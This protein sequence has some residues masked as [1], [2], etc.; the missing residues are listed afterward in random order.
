MKK[1]F[2]VFLN[3]FILC[4][5]FGYGVNAAELPEGEQSEGEEH[6][7]ATV[8]DA[9]SQITEKYDEK[10]GIA[11][12][13]LMFCAETGARD[14]IKSGYAFFI[15]DESNVYLISCYDTVILTEE[16]KNAVAASHGVT[17]DKVNTVIELVFKNDV[18]VELSVVN[19]SES[20]DFAIL[21]PSADLS[22]C[23]TLRLCTESN[24]IKEGDI[25]R[26]YD[27]D[28]NQIDCVIDDWSEIN[29]AHYFMYSS[30]YTVAKGLPLLNTDGEVV[31]IVSSANKGNPNEHFAL[32]IDEVTDVLDVLGITYNPEIIVDTTVLDEQI[33]V[34]ETLIEKQYSEESWGECQ[35]S[36]ENAVTLFENI[37]GGEVTSYTQ[38]EINEAADDLSNKIENLEK[39]GISA[40]TM[41]IIAVIEGAVLFSVII[42]LTTLLIVKTNK[43]KKQIKEVENQA[44][45][46]K[47]ALKISGRVTPGFISNNTNMPVNRSLNEAGSSQHIDMSGETSVLGVDVNY[48]NGHPDNYMSTYPTLLRYKTGESIMIKQNSFIIG[49]SMDSVDYCVRYN[50]SISRKHACIMKFEDGYY[51]QD[52][53]TTNGTYVN[54]MRVMP[55]SY[56]KLENGNIIK[57]AEEEFEFRG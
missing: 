25:V 32:Q 7:V 4:L 19:S 1:L 47:E 17:S 26:T 22:S 10:E 36:Y 53:D 23:T 48:Q 51:I 56:V 15:G 45:M 18:T 2:L 50:S 44:V 40:D 9:S 41:I 39:A 49:A 42:I 31:G 20:L 11:Y 37:A 43:Y 6:T 35:A 33:A 21:Q 24:Q 52:L 13:R 3:M 55:G 28:M 5:F 8:T 34:Y 14:I 29:N 30:D 38:D 57:L 12:I 27:A 54:N 46:A 16:E